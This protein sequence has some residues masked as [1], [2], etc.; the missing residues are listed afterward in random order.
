MKYAGLRRLCAKATT[1]SDTAAVSTTEHFA[2]DLIENYAPL[3]TLQLTGPR[4]RDT[5]LN[6]RRPGRFDVMLG[7]MQA[8]EELGGELRTL[9]AGSSNAW[10]NKSRVARVI[11]AVVLRAIKHHSPDRPRRKPRN[12]SRHVAAILA[13]RVAEPLRELR[14]FQQYG[15]A[16]LEFTAMTKLMNRLVEEVSR[17]PEAEQEAVAAWMLAE[18]DAD[19]DWDKLLASSEDLL[20][21]LAAE[22]IREDEAGLTK[23]LDPEKF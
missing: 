4:S 1:S 9:S 21:E 19:R 7:V 14:L 13:I 5:R 15:R 22:A 20:S 11:R 6:L 8:L 10:F 16:A 12:Q 3:C 2:L 17:L 23:P 18:L